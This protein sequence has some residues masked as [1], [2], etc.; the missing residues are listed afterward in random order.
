MEQ[1][2]LLS[3]PRGPFRAMYGTALPVEAFFLEG[4]FE[5]IGVKWFMLFAMCTRCSLLFPPLSSHVLV[6]KQREKKTVLNIRMQVGSFFA[7]I[8]T[9]VRRVIK[10][11]E[12][13]EGGGGQVNIKV[14]FETQQMML[15]LSHSRLDLAASTVTH[16]RIKKHTYCTVP[17][18][19]KEKRKKGE[20]SWK[21]GEERLNRLPALLTPP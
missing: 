10:E 15:N 11:E 5:A 9:Y 2:R 3:S 21:K 8:Y 13:E 18:I 4:S 19:V 16:I 1:Q 12:R 6:Q 7:P 14:P 20:G 17:Y